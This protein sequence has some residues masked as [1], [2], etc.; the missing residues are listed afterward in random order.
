MP[1]GMAN[2]SVRVCTLEDICNLSPKAELELVIILENGGRMK[3][4][5]GHFTGSLLTS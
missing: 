3:E 4:R 2:A 1:Q 5:I